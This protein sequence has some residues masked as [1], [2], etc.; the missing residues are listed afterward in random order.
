VTKPRVPAAVLRNYEKIEEEKT[1]LMVAAQ[2]QKVTEM[3]EDTLKIQARA[4]AEREA[5]VDMIN[6]N[7]EA[8]ISKI[9]A[10]MEL[11]KAK[12]T[13]EQQI[14]EKEGLKAMELLQNEIHL[15][16]EKAK[17]EALQFAVETEAEAW[18]KKLTP[19]FLKYTLYSALANNTKIYFGESIPAIM[20]QWMRDGEDIL[21]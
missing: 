18:S 21:I 6:A 13:I 16:K 5:E 7:K 10:Q 20:Q 1:R 14:A 4:R 19:E 2:E 3:Q 17:S 15:A 9:N 8:N 11:E 12:I